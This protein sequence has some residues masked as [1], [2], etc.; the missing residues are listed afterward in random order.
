MD[1][2]LKN[3]F[4][5]FL[6]MANALISIYNYYFD[7][8]FSTTYFC[9]S[10][11]S[12]F[13]VVLFSFDNLIFT[14]RYFFLGV[15]G[16]LA[17]AV[18]FIDPDAKFGHHMVASQ[19]I[20]IV[21]VMLYMTNLALLFCYF[22]FYL[23][24][25]IPVTQRTEIK[26]ENLIFLQ[27]SIVFFIFVS[28]LLNVTRGPSIIY[29]S[30]GSGSDDGFSTGLN[31]LNTIAICL[32]YFIYILY[33]KLDE[34][35]GLNKFY[36]KII[37]LSFLYFYIYVNLLHGV[38][39]DALNGMFGLF[40]IYKC[41]RTNNVNVSFKSFILVVI[42]FLIIQVIGAVRSNISSL[43]TDTIFFVINNLTS[44]SSSGILL[45]QGTLNDLATTFSGIIYLVEQYG[46]SHLYGSSYF[47]WL[48]RTPPEFLY[49][50]RPRDLA[51]LFYDNNFSSGGGFFELSE[52]FYNFGFLGA[53]I[54]P[55]FISFILALS[56]KLYRN[57]SYSILHFVVLAGFMSSLLRG[58]LYQSFAYYKASVTVVI[59]YIIILLISDVFKRAY[60]D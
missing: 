12:F 15:V 2:A 36:K 14:V 30:Y 22:G 56:L 54:V 39:M 59:L 31:N 43:S 25:K 21:S 47:D 20:E 13:S 10:L 24:N 29:G 5:L 42:A 9:F 41:V 7:V 1:I 53:A 55:F 48:A 35:C 37:I 23:G 58:A 26:N 8:D 17:A 32:S 19:S 60:Y 52:A 4:I 50:D 38:R 27:V 51:W 57:N 40:V 33:L 3:F 45:Y 6:L 28:I 11:I 49:P 44:G 18:K 46:F 16:H 34:K